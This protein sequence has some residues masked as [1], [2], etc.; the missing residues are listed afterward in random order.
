MGAFTQA[1]VGAGMLQWGERNER[2][3]GEVAQLFETY[4]QNNP[5]AS[6]ADYN[7]YL[8]QVVGP[9]DFFIRGNLPAKEMLERM[10]NDNQEKKRRDDYGNNLDF[11]AK[12]MAVNNQIQQYIEDNM[13][14]MTEAELQNSLTGILSNGDSQYEFES[15]KSATDN[16]GNYQQRRDKKV[17]KM[18][19]DVLQKGLSM[20]KETDGAA[21]ISGLFD[22]ENFKDFNQGELSQ[23]QAQLKKQFSD[24]QTR[25]NDNKN[26]LKENQKRQRTIMFHNVTKEYVNDTFRQNQLAAGGEGYVT[27]RANIIEDL[28]MA[29]IGSQETPEEIERRADIII[30]E[31]QLRGEENIKTKKTQDI[32]E[33]KKRYEDTLRTGMSILKDSNGT[34]DISVLLKNLLDDPIFKDN[35]GVL[36]QY[37]AQLKKEFS[38]EQSRLTNNQAQLKENQKRQRTIMFHNLKKEYMND[39]FRQNQLAAGGKGYAAVRANVIE[40]LQMADIGSQLTPEELEEMTNIIMKEMQLR[41]DGN[42]ETQNTKG[43]LDFTEQAFLD[44]KNQAKA[45]T[46]YLQATLNDVDDTKKGAARLATA[47]L[48]LT[49]QQAASLAAFIRGNEFSSPAE[50][51]N[52][53]RQSLSEI[54]NAQLRN[55]SDQ[56]TR[57]KR[58]AADQ[59]PDQETAIDY[60]EDFQ[61]QLVQWSKKMETTFTGIQS[62]LTSGVVVDKT[63]AIGNLEKMKAALQGNYETIKKEVEFRLRN[64][65]RWIKGSEPFLESTAQ[66]QILDPLKSQMEIL[67]ARIDALLPEKVDVKTTNAGARKETPISPTGPEPPTDQA[68]MARVMAILSEKGINKEDITGR[69]GAYMVAKLKA[70]VKQEMQSDWDEANPQAKPR[71]IR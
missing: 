20:L 9:K 7:Q 69:K 10:G 48:D 12:N 71:R 37:Q 65:E 32:L 63:T 66:S 47:D 15:R 58:L 49:T 62:M 68:I 44:I 1:G 30:K 28:K 38:D 17:K 5:Y 41:R 36:S 46:S 39:T 60:V 61:L 33:A 16:I 40:D 50:G 26:Q 43:R 27:V 3:R 54:E 24:E 67:S 31:M 14:N 35:Q 70:Q 4:K 21:D 56:R 25:L 22:D 34:A 13:M 57:A 55:I 23:Y 29:D 51:Y 59:Y 11:A 64:P 45:V 18:Y 53:W 6:A 19:D 42:I 52:K 8:E 2:R